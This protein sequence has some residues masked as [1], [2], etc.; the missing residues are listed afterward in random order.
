[1]AWANK[2]SGV[3]MALFQ[4]TEAGIQRVA[5]VSFAAEGVLERSDIQ[6]WI[7]KTP[8]VFGESLLIISEE[9]GDW[10]DSRRR[11]DLVALDED[12]NL[13]VIELKRTE[14]GGHM[15]LQSVRYAA[16]ISAMR[17]EDVVNAFEEYLGKYEPEQKDQARAR[18]LQFLGTGEEEETEISNAPRI[19]LLSDD[20]SREITTT[21]LW[22]IDQGL[23]IRCLQMVPYKVG[24]Q[25]LIDLRQVIP[26]AQAGDYQVRLHQKGEVTRQ[27]AARSRRELTLKALARHGIVREGTEIEIVPEGRPEGSANMD[28]NLFRAR[29]GD[30]SRQKSILWLDDGNGY[31]LTNLTV[32]LC[33]EHGVRW[34]GTKTALNW[35]IVGHTE[36]IWGEA[37][38]LGRHSAT[39]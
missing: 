24:G 23:R 14:D 33:Q 22:L 18:I 36:N 7:R 9:F 6:Q 38:R 25:L 12:A 34:V 16:M 1:M 28:A 10:E 2:Y 13:V 17:F 35:R 37:E 3:I 20:F 5:E 32:K 26:L 4:V 8:G 15:D 19:M 27:A 11:I 29:V 39:Q 21:V 30:L 31:S